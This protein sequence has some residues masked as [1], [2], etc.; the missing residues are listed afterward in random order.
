MVLDIK[1]DL[2]V[3]V[4]LKME[5][6]RPKQINLIQNGSGNQKS[7]SKIVFGF[8]YHLLLICR[9]DT[10]KNYFNSRVYKTFLLIKKKLLYTLSILIISLHHEAIQLILI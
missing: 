9:S 4:V 6:L 5:I 1:D 10:E 7:K 2:Q 8:K 3:Q